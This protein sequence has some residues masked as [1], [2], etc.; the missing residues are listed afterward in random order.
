MD[1]KLNFTDLSDFFA[2]N[3]G[4]STADA[5]SFLHTF[6]D[7]IVEGLE[8]DGIVKINGLGTFKVV[9]VESRSSVNINTGERFEIN[10]H[11]R[12]TFIPADSLKEII[13][14][15]FA[16][17]E[18]VEV[19]DDIDDEE[20]EEEKEF[21]INEETTVEELAIAENMLPDE[22]ISVNEE[23]IVAEAKET[24]VRV[25]EIEEE[26]PQEVAA[27]ENSIVSANIDEEMP[28]EE[29]DYIPEYNVAEKIEEEVGTEKEI[30][31]EEAVVTE[32]T[33]II[34]ESACI[35]AEE[36]KCEETVI[37][38]AIVPAA[39]ETSKKEIRIPEKGEKEIFYH[40]LPRK[41]KQNRF[42]KV[43][44]L[45]ALIIACVAGAFIGLHF[46]KQNI[47]PTNNLK[48]QIAVTEVEK[49]EEVNVTEN[50]DSTEVDSVVVAN[51]STI[52]IIA[53]TIDAE[54]EAVV[55]LEDS[56]AKD[57]IVP[58]IQLK[59]EKPEK[60][61]AES[62]KVVD[63]LARRELSTIFVADTTDYR[64]AGTICTHKVKSE[65]TLIRI[66]QKY[67]GDK[68]LWP[69]IVKYNNMIR[70]NELACDMLLKIPKLVPKK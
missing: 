38:E 39:E 29:S 69:Y 58:V 17:F 9:E 2:K 65:E 28:I 66:S 27:E 20:E 59:E 52:N 55:S 48:E 44:I 41:K 42:S 35:N 34:E 68:R 26:M 5:E 40:T 15:P 53:D 11:N 25:A 32:E 57:T 18:P 67:Y 30:S 63:A 56:V 24:I 70:P 31:A 7:I 8:K 36:E 37:V 19:D 1:K 45:F 4:V 23:N 49:S 22:E 16:M 43:A 60:K 12:L 46:Y 21:V 61:P 50:I 10:G 51:D 47:T 54:K 13:N 14:A 62:F 33:E 3:V 6:F 64:I